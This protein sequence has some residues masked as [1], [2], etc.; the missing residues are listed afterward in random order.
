MNNDEH[1]TVGNRVRIYRRGSK[2]IFCAD[3]W[4]DGKHRR[5]SLKTRNRKV[6]V[7]RTIDLSHSLK[8]GTFQ[9]NTKKTSLTEARELFLSFL[10]TE[11]RAEG[12]IVR[13]RGE[14]QTFLEFC[15]LRRIK[16]LSAVTPTLMDAYRAERRKRVE[17]PTVNHETSVVKGLLRW[18]RSRHLVS[19]NPLAEYSVSKAIP[20]KRIA[21]TLEEVQAIFRKSPVRLLRILATL[22]CSGM[23]VGE[24][25]H[26]LVT[27]VDLRGNWFHIES[28]EGAE[29]KMRRSRKIPI[30]QTLRQ[31]LTENQTPGPWFFTAPPSAKYPEGCHWISPKKV[32]DAFQRIADGIGLPTGRRRNGYTVHS[33]R[34]FFETFTVNSRIPQRVVDTWMGHRSDRSM[35]A[36]YYTL[37]DAESQRF[38]NEVPF[39]FGADSSDGVHPSQSE[40]E[41]AQQ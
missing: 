7:D 36:V 28:R 23:R 38:M 1:E 9:Q 8:E 13:Y 41:R 33:L 19:A 11:G 4:H 29:T 26:L 40:N 3:F 6:A 10:I 37:A 16:R 39:S 15:D 21:P 24:L 2:G 31:M 25:Q 12:T 32:N 5:V 27:D 35:G 17:L 18:S 14:L 34:H 20:K 30:H 22:V